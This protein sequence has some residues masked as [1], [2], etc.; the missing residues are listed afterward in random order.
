MFYFFC[1]FSTYFGTD[2]G[3]IFMQTCHTYLGPISISLYYKIKP[4]Y[5]RPRMDEKNTKSV[6]K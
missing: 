3:Y 1:Y 2:V 5:T 6:L 4:V